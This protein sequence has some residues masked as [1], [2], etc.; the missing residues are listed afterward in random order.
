MEIFRILSDIIGALLE[1]IISFLGYLLKPVVII[2]IVL[3]VLCFIICIVLHFKDKHTV[4][5]RYT[6]SCIP[7]D[8]M[9]SNDKTHRSCAQCCY[10][11]RSEQS[12]VNLYCEN[13]DIDV[14][15][16]HICRSYQIRISTDE[17]KNKG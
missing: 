15:P 16:N 11:K 2:V 10:H 3:A 5:P 6:K 13:Y 1:P 17:Q 9:E 14:F 8:Y 4:I 7:I 12:D